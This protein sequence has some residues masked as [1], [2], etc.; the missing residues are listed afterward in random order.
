[1][2]PHPRLCRSL[3][4]VNPQSQFFRYPF[5]N[6][7]LQAIA[8][9]RGILVIDGKGFQKQGSW[10]QPAFSLQNFLALVPGMVEETLVFKENTTKH[11][12]AG[13]IVSMSEY[14]IELTIDV[15]SRSVG[16]IRL[17]SQTRFCPIQDSFMK[18]VGMDCCTTFI[19]VGEMAL[20]Y[21]DALPCEEIEQGSGNYHQAEYCR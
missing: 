1:M 14:P 17:H 4:D 5:A 11:A 18:A 3:A 8:E 13:D 15:I 21:Y 12:L 16:D 9:T 2:N 6:E 19:M 7:I 20:S 10:S